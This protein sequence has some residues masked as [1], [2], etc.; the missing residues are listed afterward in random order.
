MF[1]IKEAPQD[2]NQSVTKALSRLK[3]VDA[4]IT[5][6]MTD[7]FVTIVKQGMTSDG[8]HVK[9]HHD[10]VHRKLKSIRDIIEQDYN[11]RNEIAKKMQKQ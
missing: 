1:N 6:K 7:R 11:T 9:D 2:N 10:Q 8:K 3:M 4:K 5:D